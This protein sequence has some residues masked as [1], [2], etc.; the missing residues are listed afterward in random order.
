MTHRVA[1]RPDN[2][3]GVKTGKRRKTKCFYCRKWR[4]SIRWCSDCRHF[5]C[6]WEDCQGSPCPKARSK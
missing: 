4:A 3:I 6:G 2:G 1:P 5:V